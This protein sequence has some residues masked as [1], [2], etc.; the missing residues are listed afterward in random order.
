LSTTETTAI[1]WWFF[2]CKLFPVGGLG[3]TLSLGQAASR[4]EFV[5]WFSGWDCMV[6]SCGMETRPRHPALKLIYKHKRNPYG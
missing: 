1:S 5:N 2:I 6:A 4:K 3:L